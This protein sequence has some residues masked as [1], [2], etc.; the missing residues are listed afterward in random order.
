MAEK[1]R[2]RC[3][4]CKHTLK[5]RFGG[6]KCRL[7]SDPQT[8]FPGTLLASKFFWCQHCEK[9]YISPDEFTTDKNKELARAGKFVVVLLSEDRSTKPVEVVDWIKPETLVG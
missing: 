2:G 9:G 8:E 3:P 5:T 7:A 4:T 6:L 1:T